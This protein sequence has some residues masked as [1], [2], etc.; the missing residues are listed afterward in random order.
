MG[1]EF[2]V[3]NGVLQYKKNDRGRPSWG[4]VDLEDE[5]NLE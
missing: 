3:K 1:T 5:E 4:D 2:R